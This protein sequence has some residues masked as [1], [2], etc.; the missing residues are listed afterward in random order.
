MAAPPHG[1]RD[2][3]AIPLGPALP[4]AS[5]NL[6]ERWAENLPEGS[7][8]L[9]FLFGFAPGGVYRAAPVTRARGGLLL[10]PFTLTAPKGRGGLLSVAL[11]LGLPPPGVTRHRVS[12]EPG[13]SSHATFRR[14]RMRPSDRLAVRIKGFTGRKAMPPAFIDFPKCAEPSGNTRRTPSSSASHHGRHCSAESSR[15]YRRR[16]TGMPWRDTAFRI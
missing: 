12:V 4:P 7:A 8:F 6:P 15:R 16:S 9:P 3:T 10:H 14:L 2:V 1:R 13:L 5:S 11:S